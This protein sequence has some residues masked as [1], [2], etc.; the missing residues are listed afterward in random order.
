M[1]EGLTLELH[2]LLKPLAQ[3]SVRY[4]HESVSTDRETNRKRSTE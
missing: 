2:G 3:A 4:H 1:S